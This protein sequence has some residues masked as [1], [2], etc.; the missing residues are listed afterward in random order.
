MSDW[1]QMWLDGRRDARWAGS[2]TIIRKVHRDSLQGDT[3]GFVGTQPTYGSATVPERW[4]LVVSDTT[5]AEVYL[6]VQRE[7]WDRV[8]VGETYSA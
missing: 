4:V 7:I 8:D 2:G 3:I 6:E 5:G 1:I